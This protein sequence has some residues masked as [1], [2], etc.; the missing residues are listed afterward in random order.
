MNSYAAKA[1]EQ[2]LYNNYANPFW[3]NGF[4]DFGW[5]EKLPCYV[6]RVKVTGFHCNRMFNGGYEECIKELRLA[7]QL[8]F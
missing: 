4:R 5:H 1:I 3:L 6:N 2:G 7:T 8:E